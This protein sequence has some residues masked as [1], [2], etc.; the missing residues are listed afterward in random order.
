MKFFCVVREK[1]HH[2]YTEKKELQLLQTQDILCCYLR[3]SYLKHSTQFQIMIFFCQIHYIYC[4][5]NVIATHIW[6]SVAP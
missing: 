1:K 3:I 4:E 6:K 5:T 2:S